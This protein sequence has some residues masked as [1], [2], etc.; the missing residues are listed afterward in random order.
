MRTLTHPHIKSLV[1]CADCEPCGCTSEEGQLDL[2]EKIFER[3]A[4][5]TRVLQSQ[6]TILP[7][8]HKDSEMDGTVVHNLDTEQ[9]VS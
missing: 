7:G 8:L 3:A 4:R 1:T 2:A 6:L 5:Y 9:T